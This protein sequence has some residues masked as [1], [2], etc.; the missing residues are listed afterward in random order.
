MGRSALFCFLTPAVLV[1]PILI[2]QP[3]PFVIIMV[4]ATKSGTS[5][6][7]IEFIARDCDA[8]INT[9]EQATGAQGVDQQYQKAVRKIHHRLSN[10]LTSRFPGAKVSVIDRST[11]LVWSVDSM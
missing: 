3:V 11:D 6:K 5:E 9:L 10:V 2:Q 8:A 4:L 7:D 1:S